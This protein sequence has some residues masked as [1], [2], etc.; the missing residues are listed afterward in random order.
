[1]QDSMLDQ[2]HPDEQQDKGLI[3]DMI[4]EVLQKVIDDMNSLETDRIMPMDKKP[5]VMSA[6]IEAV[7]PVEEMPEDESDLDPGVLDELLGKAEK[8]DDSGSL[9]EDGTDE[10]EPELAD[11]VRKKKIA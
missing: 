2:G 4:K 8:A 10:L 5:Q 6:K 1:M 11:I 9:P 7:K 3:K